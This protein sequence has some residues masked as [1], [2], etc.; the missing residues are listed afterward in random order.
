M[1]N[2]HLPSQR[3]TGI[4]KFSLIYLRGSTVG[5]NVST[6]SSKSTNSSLS[7]SFADKVLSKS[8]NSWSIWWGFGVKGKS[9]WK[10]H[11]LKQ[12]RKCLTGYIRTICNHENCNSKTMFAFLT[13]FRENRLFSDSFF[14]K[15][16]VKALYQDKYLLLYIFYTIYRAPH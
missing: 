7:K 6:W 8:S 2:V 4:G 12:L 10:P 13:Y 14:Q 9:V 3:G 15:V 16:F 5:S 11:L 1:N